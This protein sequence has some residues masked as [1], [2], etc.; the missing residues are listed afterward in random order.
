MNYGR[1]HYPLCERVNRKMPEHKRRLRILPPIELRSNAGS[2]LLGAR[3]HLEEAGRLAQTRGVETLWQQES[4]LDSETRRQ[5]QHDVNRFHWHVRAF[6][7]E[8]VATYDTLLHWANQM[9]DLGISEHKVSRDEVM[10][11]AEKQGKYSP[12]LQELT[13]VYESEWYF[14]VRQYRNFAH[15]AFLFIQG[16]YDANNKLVLQWLLPARE[17]QR[18]NYQ[19]LLQLDDYLAQMGN[20]VQRIFRAS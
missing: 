4:G 8:L 15:R 10:A 9:L 16:E 14:E 12:E 5:L 2:A 3:Y 17:G 1:P 18:E 7:W 20:L 11:Q 13:K 19:A 6:F